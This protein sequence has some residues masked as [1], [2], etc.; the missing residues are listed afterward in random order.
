MFDIVTFKKV[1][2]SF[3]KMLCFHLYTAVKG[4]MAL[5]EL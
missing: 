4:G 3:S 1:N 2:G 5:P